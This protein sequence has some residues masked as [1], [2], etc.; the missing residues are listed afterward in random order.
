[1][2]LDEDGRKRLIE[3]WLERY[4]KDLPKEIKSRLI[5]AD[6][7]KTPLFLRVVLD[8][9]RVSSKHE[10]LEHDLNAFLQTNDLVELF[11]RVLQNVEGDQA[12]G[13]ALAREALSLIFASRMGLEETEL[14]ELLGETN[15]RHLAFLFA[16]M[17]EYLTRVDGR[18]GFLH[19]ALRQAVAKRYS[20]EGETLA[21]LHRRLANY[22]EDF[23]LGQRQLDEYPW[24]LSRL[25]EWER[26][27]QWLGRL[28]VFREFHG[29]DQSQFEFSVYW[30]WL[31]GSLPMQNSLM[32]LEG[33]KNELSSLDDA[34][35]RQTIVMFTNF[36]NQLLQ[37][38]QV[39][40]GSLAKA[41][42]LLEKDEPEVVATQY[43]RPRWLQDRDDLDRAAKL[44]WEI[45]KQIKGG[46]DPAVAT[47][48]DNLAYVFLY[49]GRLEAA[50]EWFQ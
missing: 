41:G 8:E 16:R 36:C 4:R 21:A 46:R 20:L 28:D 48:M 26:L 19:D 11:A 40:S 38:M 49:Q 5:R 42:R 12:H 17:A 18:Y 13:G 33:Y 37:G 29:R 39:D 27:R 6:Q 44:F 9:L 32:M 25:E 15:A 34:D 43:V 2:P 10:A 47:G 14:R 31:E 1:K 22:F 35:R 3:T 30:Q 45:L 24:H 7:S 50:E 23:P